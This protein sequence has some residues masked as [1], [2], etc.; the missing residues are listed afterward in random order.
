LSSLRDFKKNLEVLYDDVTKAFEIRSN[1]FKYVLTK[2]QVHA[3]YREQA[4]SFE[5]EIKDFIAEVDEE[6]EELELIELRDNLS[7]LVIFKYL[8]LVVYIYTHW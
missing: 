6:I 7:S 4:A 1:E 2:K 5:K 8:S 3:L